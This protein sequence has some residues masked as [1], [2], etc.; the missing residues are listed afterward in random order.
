MKRSNKVILHLLSGHLKLFIFGI[1]TLFIFSCKEYNVETFPVTMEDEYTVREG[2]CGTVIL[3]EQL[4]KSFSEAK[5]IYFTE[6]SKFYSSSCPDGNPC[7]SIQLDYLFMEVIN[8]NG[9]IPEA[10]FLGMRVLNKDS[11]NL[12]ESVSDVITSNGYHY[13]INR[14]KE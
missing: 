5:Q 11:G 4:G 1:T 8:S 12:L 7:I 9:K 6:K 10:E 2:I 3:K 14:C 13:E